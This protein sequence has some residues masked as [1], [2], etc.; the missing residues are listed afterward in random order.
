MGGGGETYP[1]PWQKIY[2][3]ETLYSKFFEIL[4]PVLRTY[5]DLGEELAVQENKEA[6]TAARY[7][8]EKTLKI[9]VREGT[10]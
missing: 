1:F 8:D 10:K 5:E 7:S 3:K 9:F 4:V 2:G 6:R